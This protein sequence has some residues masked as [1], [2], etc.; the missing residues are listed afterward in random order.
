MAEVVEELDGMEELTLEASVEIQEEAVVG[1]AV[2]EEGLE[3]EH[4]VLPVV[5]EH[6]WHIFSRRFQLPL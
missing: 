5:V 4:A 3:S 6:L 2:E 1:A